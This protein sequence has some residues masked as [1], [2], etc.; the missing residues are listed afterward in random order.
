MNLNMWKNISRD[1]VL[2]VLIDFQEKFFPILKKSVVKLVKANILLL[3]KMFKELNIPMIGTEHYVKGLGHTE[4]DVLKKWGDAPM[5]GKVIFNCCGDEKFLQNLEKNSRPVVVIAGLETHICVLQT[6]LDLLE[7]NYQ[8][9]VLKDAVVS[10]TR[11]KWANGIQLMK[12]AGAHIL[13]TETL[14]FYLLKRA[15][16]KEFKYLVKL[17]EQQNS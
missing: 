15:D 12:E 17:L 16:T 8:V 9:V 1:N 3:I 10:S 2:F 11:L 6:V 5:T 7:R 4:K 14:L 13:N